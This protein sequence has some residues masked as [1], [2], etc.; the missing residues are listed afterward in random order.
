MG[1]KMPEKMVFEVSIPES[2]I[3]SI[4]EKTAKRVVDAISEGPTSMPEEYLAEVV[5]KVVVEKMLGSL[6]KGLTRSDLVDLLSSVTPSDGT[7]DERPP[8]YILGH[9]L[10]LPREDGIRFQKLTEATAKFS[11][12]DKA[13]EDIAV[14]DINKLSLWKAAQM[15]MTPDEVV[16]I[17]KDHAASPPSQSLRVWIAQ[18]MSLYGALRIVV[19][20]EGKNLFNVLEF[21][22]EDIAQQ[23]MGI[24]DVKA[25]IFTTL[26]PTRFRIVKDHR[27][28]IKRVLID[29]GYPVR[30]FG[31]IDEAPPITIEWKPGEEAKLRPYQLEARAQF[32]E[33]HRGV[34][35]LPPGSGKTR[36][37]ISAIVDR[38]LSTLFITNKAEVCNQ[39]KKELVAVTN[40]PEGR[41]AVIHGDSRDRYLQDITATTYQMVTGSDSSIA[42]EIWKRKW[43][44]IVADECLP[45]D[46]K[47]LL[48]N[49]ST[50]S[51]GKIVEK[52][53]PVEVL[54]YNILT[55]S[56]ERKRVIGFY[57]L[58]LYRPLCEIKHEYGL[59][60]CT[61]DHPIYTLNR[62]YIPASELTVEDYIFSSRDVLNY[63]IHLQ[64]MR[65]RV[66]ELTSVGW[67]RGDGSQ[68]LES[69]KAVSQTMGTGPTRPTEGCILQRH[70]S[71]K[72]SRS[73]EWQLGRRGVNYPVDSD[74]GGGHSRGASGGYEHRP[75][76][77]YMESS[78]KNK[79]HL[80]ASRVCRVVILSP[81]ESCRH[82][83]PSRQEWGIWERVISIYYKKLSLFKGTLRS[84]NSK[85]KKNSHSIMAN[86]DED[87]A[88]P[89][90]RVYG[91]W[92]YQ[93]KITSNRTF[94]RLL[95]HR[96]EQTLSQL[97]RFVLG[98]GSYNSTFKV[99]LDATIEKG[100]DAEVPKVS[101]AVHSSLDE[102][103]TRFVYDI[104]VEDNHNFFADGVLV[105]NCQHIPSAT[106]RR[107][108]EIQSAYLLG[109]TATPIRED[110]LEKD[111]FSLIGPP[112]IDLNWLEVADQGFISKIKFYEVKVQLPARIQP[113]YN[114]GKPFERV[115]VLAGNPA[116][117]LAVRRILE[118]HPSAPTLIIGFYKDAA[119][120]L[121]DELGI[122]VVSGEMTH[123]QKNQQYEAFRKGET[124]RLILTSVGE[125]GVDLPDA[126]VGINV[127]GLYGGR[128]GFSQRAGR[129]LRPKDGDSYFYELV[130]EGTEE[131]EWSEKRRAYLVG[132][133]YNFETIDMTK[134]NA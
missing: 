77:A 3:Q 122:P 74:S 10:Y 40:F 111:I 55:H 98:R 118:I 9:E 89:S 80:R 119:F 133:G 1:E 4:S 30:D 131:E 121:G 15:G 7:H 132:Q 107:T 36:I 109:L 82:T 87:T 60:H 53:L 27:Y 88:C 125:E 39:F 64:K 70:G 106:W 134:E 58:P 63:D 72:T 20:G 17:L 100:I 115:T 21:E 28:A 117:T 90:G 35:V 126:R 129:I 128:M 99:E 51:I 61:I 110:G 116:K 11:R 120:A 59:L 108:E 68:S 33:N 127:A 130:T 31:L 86:F 57:K 44:L 5:A 26:T 79:P 96:G 24:R 45:Y 47:I 123:S 13:S 81:E 103:Q 112:L 12:L 67:T 32:K 23:V 48:G 18:M 14:Y 73:L 113:A 8:L 95:L 78:N 65:E 41:V 83:T 56:L 92:K 66:S 101:E 104:E 22:N 42:K 6:P 16:E 114:K 52:N 102:V 37:A 105:H 34:V 29:K 71:E 84:N 2:T 54:S 49:G 97:A 43:G 46:T 85:G 93:P 91:R 75:A 76:E 124:K 94:D 38:K 62:G 19:D 25:H 50:E 69:I